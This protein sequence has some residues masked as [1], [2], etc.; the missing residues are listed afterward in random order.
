MR[1]LHIR[2]AEEADAAL[3]LHFIKELAAW[4]GMGDQVAATEA[5][6]RSSLFGRRQAEAIIGEADGNPAAFALFFH[7]YSTFLGKANLFLEDLFVRKP[8]RGG[9]IGTA[10]LQRLAQIAAGRGCG[11]LDWLVLDDNADGAAF[12]RKHGATALTDRRIYRLEAERLTAF[13]ES[14]CQAVTKKL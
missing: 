14:S 2:Y 7:S 5:D 1:S 6:I 10:M 11:R 9:G 8:Y 3:I 13:A 4:E 12:Y